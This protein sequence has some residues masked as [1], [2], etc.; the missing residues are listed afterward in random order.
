MVS[1]DQVTNPAVIIFTKAPIPGTVKTR[2]SPPLSADEAATLH[3]TLVLD[4]IE[5]AKG[6]PGRIVLKLELFQHTGSFKPRGAFSKILASEV[7]A[8]GVSPFGNGF[9]SEYGPVGGPLWHWLLVKPER[10]LKQADGK[11]DVPTLNELV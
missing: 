10:S 8:A 4:A 1:R 9:T 6:L 11:G 3:G 2:L 5:R 7:P